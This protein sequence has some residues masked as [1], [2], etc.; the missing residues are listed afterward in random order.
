MSHTP[1]KR[2]GQHFL[3]DQQV[4]HTIVNSI[5]PQ[6]NDH[7]IEIGPGEGVLTKLLQPQVQQLTCIEI[8]RDLVHYL[9]QQLAN[10]S[11]LQIYEADALSFDYAKHMMSD[12]NN[13]IVGNLPYNISTP[14]L[15]KLF[16][17]ANISD[18]TFLLQ[19]EVVNRL[20]ATP[21]NKN[22]GRLSV[23]SQY[24]C[25]NAL[26]FEV[27]PEAFNPPPKVQS[28]VVHLK[29][30]TSKLE[31][32]DIKTLESIVRLAFNKRRKTLANCLKGVISADQL[33]TLD[34]DPTLR[35]ENLPVD[36]FVRISN[37]LALQ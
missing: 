14:L 27:P 8:D 1:R 2:F 11:N 15:F 36:A 35:P 28:A 10:I 30:R 4:L 20:V 5:K 23:M 19:L 13:R 7:I 6:A 25:N 34:I 18:F 9:Q 22:Y 12:V 21:G 16:N 24:F 33:M 17:L 31:A 3:Q 37:A 26:L 32:H 29:P